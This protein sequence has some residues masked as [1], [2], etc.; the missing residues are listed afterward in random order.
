MKKKV[1][2]LMM[3]LVLGLFGLAQAQVSLPY[4]EG[5]ENGIG[6]WTMSNC[7][8]NSGVTASYTAYEGSSSFS[9]YYTTTPPQYLISPELT[10]GA[11]GVE[12]SFFYAI[13]SSTW[14][15]TFQVGYS[16]TTNATSAFTWG[17]EVTATNEYDSEWLEYTTTCPAGT[18][19]VAVKCT[20]NDR[21]R[22]FVDGFTFTAVGG[23]DTPVAS[24]IYDF[25]DSTMQ[26]WTAIDADGDG[27][28]WVLGSQIG[29]VYLVDGA[30]LA[31]S[32]NNASNDM[33]CSGSYSNETGA[34]LYPDNYLVSPQVTLGGSISF[35]ACGQDANYA[36]EHFGVFVS[37]TGTNPSDFTMVNEWTIGSRTAGLRETVRGNRA[38]TTWTEYNAD[39]SAYSGQGYVAIRHFNCSDQFILDI[40]DI[41]ITEP[42]SE[43]L[44]TSS[45]SKTTKS[46]LNGATMPITPGR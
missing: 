42:S 22:L 44:A 37:T 36:A 21:F 43:R 13:Y 17:S 4:S 33:V 31:G 45:I 20:S 41:A 8:S 29:G 9:F 19:Y 2:S 25:E 26:G 27:Y 24:D 14:S 15:E 3:A 10:G 35:Y 6:S 7:H 38:Q 12:V 16:T 28:N 34:I 39:L 40:D 5:F 1:F 11:N 30:S 46:P 32:G 18:K 23:G